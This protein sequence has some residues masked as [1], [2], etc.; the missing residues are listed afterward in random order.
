MIIVCEMYV[1]CVIYI[2][3]VI[4]EIHNI[5]IPMRKNVSKSTKETK[6]HDDVNLIAL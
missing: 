5:Q 4:S 6:T 3:H 2:F 1:I